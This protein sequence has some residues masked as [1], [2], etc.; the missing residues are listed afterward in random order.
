MM[1]RF[2]LQ[3]KFALFPHSIDTCKYSRGGTYLVLPLM[4][5]SKLLEVVNDDT[6]I[7]TVVH[8]ERWSAHPRLE[9]VHGQRDV[10][11]V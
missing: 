11:R 6:R 4:L 5:F 7:G 10:L 2:F 3:W 8:V 9:V 1:A